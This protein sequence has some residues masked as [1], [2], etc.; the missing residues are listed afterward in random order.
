LA[1]FLDVTRRAAEKRGRMPTE[2]SQNYLHHRASTGSDCAD[3][4]LNKEPLSP[5][6]QRRR[7]D[8]YTEHFV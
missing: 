6:E 1:H 2:S 8:S 5:G 7:R 4:F 3:F